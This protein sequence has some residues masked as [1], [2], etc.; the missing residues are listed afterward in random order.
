MNQ[1]LT[2]QPNCC[3][4]IVS[5]SSPVVVLVCNVVLAIFALEPIRVAGGLVQL[6]VSRLQRFSEALNFA[7]DIDVYA[8]FLHTIL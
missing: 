7:L 2:P 6:K 1:L 5:S 8:L 3:P 4:R